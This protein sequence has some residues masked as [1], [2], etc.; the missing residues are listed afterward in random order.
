MFRY[1]DGNEIHVGDHVRHA[2]ASAYVEQLVVGEDAESWG[3]D[4][5]GFLLICE[6][7]GRILIEPGSYDWE[8]VEFVR[9]GEARPPVSSDS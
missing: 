8:D 5:S 6:Q 3:L 9:R 4:E 7:C 2:G 1:R